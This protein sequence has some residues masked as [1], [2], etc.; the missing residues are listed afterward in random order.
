VNIFNQGWLNAIVK[1]CM[2]I[3]QVPGLEP[4]TNP[5]LNRRFCCS[6]AG[7][8]I[9]ELPLLS[10]TFTKDDK[11]FVA[12]TGGGLSP[13]A[14]AWLAMAKN[15]NGIQAEKHLFKALGL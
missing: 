2:T 13:A 9:T 10:R 15:S 11:Q 4:V 14:L 5:P 7:S 6:N 8:I 3:V 12:L 1:G